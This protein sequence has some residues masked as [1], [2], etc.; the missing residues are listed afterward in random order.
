[1]DVHSKKQRSYNMSQIRGRDT[2]PE[3]TLRKALWSRGFRY[4][5]KSRLPGRPDIVLSSRKVV[6]FVDGCFWHKC[7]IHYQQ[8]ASNVEFWRRKIAENV[9]RD[10]RNSS[11]LCDD[12]W[13]VLRVWEHEVNN[14]LDDVLAT[15]IH[16]VRRLRT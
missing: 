8:P 14:S 7:P 11:R 1:M 10:E 12:G 16:A 3:L 9:S 5:I 15:I 4:R 2:K 6:V 13:T